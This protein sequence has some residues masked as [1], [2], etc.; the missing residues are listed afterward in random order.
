[1]DLL[2]FISMAFVPKYF[3]SG[4]PKVIT[5]ELGMMI[6]TN[7]RDFLLNFREQAQ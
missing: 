3:F 1:M 6:Q 2:I 4:V 5:V 7:E